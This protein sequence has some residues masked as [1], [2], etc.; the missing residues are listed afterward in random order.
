MSVR[1]DALSRIA[2][3]LAFSVVVTG[4]MLGAAVSVL[5]VA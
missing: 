2:A 4:V 5:P 1:F 3:S